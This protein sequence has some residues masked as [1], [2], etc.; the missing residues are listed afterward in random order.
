M[1]GFHAMFRFVF[2]FHQVNV[3][4]NARGDGGR[5]IVDGVMQL[6]QFSWL[7]TYP[8]RTL[9]AYDFVIPDPAQPERFLITTHEEMW[10]LGDMIQAIPLVGRFYSDVFRPAFARGFLVASRVASRR[11]AHAGR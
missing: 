5:A 6:K 9:L 8:L 4:L 3:Q 11:A 7:Y 10:S 2:E 1:A